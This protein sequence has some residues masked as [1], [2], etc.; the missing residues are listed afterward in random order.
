MN[1]TINYLP[2]EMVKEIYAFVPKW[3]KV[4]LNKKYYIKYHKHIK[5]KFINYDGYLRNIVRNDCDFIFQQTCSENMKKWLLIKQY[6][7]KNKVFSNYVYLLEHLCIETEST[8]CRNILHFYIKKSGLNKNQHKKK[9]SKVIQKEW[10][11]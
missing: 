10:S 4:Y 3:I 7:Y 6:K 9:V 2:E 8:K 1:I 11:N 5:H